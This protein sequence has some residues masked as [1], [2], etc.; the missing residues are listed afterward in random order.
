M[1][2]P[3][4]A[5]FYLTVWSSNY[6]KMR[7][8]VKM[9]LTLLLQMFRFLGF[10]FYMYSYSRQTTLKTAAFLL[11]LT[12]FGTCVWNLAQPMHWIYNPDRLKEVLADLEP[13][14]EFRPQSANPFYRRTT[15]EQTCY[16]DQAY[17][18]LESLSQCGGTG[19]HPDRQ[20]RCAHEH[21]SFILGIL[22]CLV[23]LPLW[24]D[25]R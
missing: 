9:K 15:G 21:N 19:V 1:K 11:F 14:P 8:A 10:T 2:R 12:L 16:G 20:Q 18:L 4:F 5:C 7:T 6:S 25:Q 23:S 3:S 13:C 17:V 24:Y 22:M